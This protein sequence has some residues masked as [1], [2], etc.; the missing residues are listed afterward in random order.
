MCK[1]FILVHFFFCLWQKIK[2][3]NAVISPYSLWQR[4]AK[5]IAQNRLGWHFSSLSNIGSVTR[6]FTITHIP[7]LY[8]A[9]FD[10]CFSSIAF[11]SA[12]AWPPGSCSHSPLTTWQI[13]LSP[14]L[15]PSIER[16]I[17]V[18]P[19]LPS[20]YLGTVGQTQGAFFTVHWVLACF[21][22]VRGWGQAA[23]GWGEREWD[24]AELFLGFSKKGLT[25]N[26][27]VK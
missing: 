26:G 19:S 4:L 23:R 5:I 16:Q 9:T 17:F 13:L 11:L 18:I 22:P 7:N 10:S 8:N 3:F 14:F 21:A 24:G 6:A 15:P 12:C 2:R 27:L 25:K 1:H 20:K